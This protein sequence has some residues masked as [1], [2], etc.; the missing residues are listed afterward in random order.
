M[1][2][3]ACVYVCT[4]KNLVYTATKMTVNNTY[5]EASSVDI[6]YSVCE[7]NLWYEK[8]IGV[9]YFW[10]FFGHPPTPKELYNI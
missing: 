2:M 3:C 1:C 5:L 4:Y 7:N 10:T 8:K 6:I 9:T